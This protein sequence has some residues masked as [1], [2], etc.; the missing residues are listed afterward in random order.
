MYVTFTFVYTLMISQLPGT[1]TQNDRVL[2]FCSKN[3]ILQQDEWI[4]MYFDFEYDSNAI[5]MSIYNNIKTIH[6]GLTMV[7]QRMFNELKG[8]SCQIKWQQCS[9]SMVTT[10][11]FHTKLIIIWAKC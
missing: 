8:G 4:M 7:S 10:S 11:R 5:I 2:Q 3:Q 1:F 9:L 6:I